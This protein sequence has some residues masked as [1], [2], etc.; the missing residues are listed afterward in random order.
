MGDHGEFIFDG[1]RI[2][3]DNAVLRMADGQQNLQALRHF[4]FIARRGAFEWIVSENSK[5][6]ALARKNNAH[7]TWFWEVAH[8]SNDCISTYGTTRESRQLA[9]HL[10]SHMFGYLSDKDR[11]LLRDAVALRYDAFV[12]IE[13]ALPRNADYIKRVIGIR[14]LTPIDLWN[15]IKPWAALLI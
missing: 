11:L 8:H 3:Q 4:C 10:N 2:E 13:R 15:A 12:T 9:E 14:V 6:E 1:G 7:T 5:H